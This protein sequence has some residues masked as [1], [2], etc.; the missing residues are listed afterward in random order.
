MSQ[1]AK[2]KLR[3]SGWAGVKVSFISLTGKK[4]S[5]CGA[6]KRT[7]KSIDGH[8]HWCPVR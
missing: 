6:T 4:C 3:D 5:W 8:L 7:R 1:K 2:L